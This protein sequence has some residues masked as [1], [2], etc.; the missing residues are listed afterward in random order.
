MKKHITQ[1][2]EKRKEK[3]LSILELCKLTDVNLQDFMN[4]LHG[5]GIS[6]K[7]LNKLRDVFGIMSVEDEIKMKLLTKIYNKKL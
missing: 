1:I 4:F 7:N 2:I 6:C 5:K 3:N